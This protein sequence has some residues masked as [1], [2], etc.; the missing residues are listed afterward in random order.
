MANPMLDV[1]ILKSD[2]YCRWDDF[3]KQHH[4]QNLFSLSAWVKTMAGLNDAMP[5]IIV[6]A[7]GEKMVAGLAGALSR[8]FGIRILEPPMFT[9][10]NGIIAD[11]DILERIGEIIIGESILKYLTKI[12]DRLVIINWPGSISLERIGSMRPKI[13]LRHTSIIDL[14]DGMASSRGYKPDVRNKINKANRANI[15]VIESY[16]PECLYTLMRKTFSRAEAKIKL[17][18]GSFCAALSDINGNNWLRMF[19]AFKEKMPVAAMAILQYKGTAYSWLSATDPAYYK[20]GVGPKLTDWILVKLSSEGFQE[21]DFMGINI[22]GIGR[23]KESFG[24]RRAAYI[25]QDYAFGIK[26]RSFR[27]IQKVLRG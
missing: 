6:C 8:R 4:P 15:K 10:H 20:D 19:L 11:H 26:G 12:C 9:P 18:R 21:F 25:S 22:Q 23:Y 2:D 24:G 16:D 3:V 27:F 17:T 14:Q 1:Q 13:A 7:I 5:V